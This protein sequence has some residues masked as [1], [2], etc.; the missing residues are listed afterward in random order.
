LHENS[1][2]TVDVIGVVSKSFQFTG[3]ADFQ[4]LPP[5]LSSTGCSDVNYYQMNEPLENDY[6]AREVPIFQTPSYFTKFDKPTFF[7]FR[8]MEETASKSSP[9]KEPSENTSDS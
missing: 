3:M 1:N 7:L 9:I 2:C 4:T 8:S 6:C 5:G